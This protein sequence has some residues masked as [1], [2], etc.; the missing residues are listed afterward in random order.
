MLFFCRIFCIQLLLVSPVWL[1]AQAAPTVLVAPANWQQ[2]GLLIQLRD[3]LNHP[4]MNWPLTRL[5]YNLDFKEAGVAL[6]SLHLRDAGTG[7][8]VPFQLTDVQLT[9]GSVRKATLYFLTDLPSGS[10]KTFRLTSEKGSAKPATLE[11]ISVVSIQKNA[12]TLVLSNGFVRAELPLTTNSSKPVPPMLR[13]GNATTWLGSGVLTAGLKPTS[14]T[15]TEGSIGPLLAEYKLA[16]TFGKIK[17]YTATIRLV[18][19]M[20]F[21]ELDERM[22]GFS[23]N[24]SLAWQLVWDHLKPDFRYT[25]NRP[26]A[27]VNPS[28]K[29]YTSFAWEPIGGGPID[30]SAK[31]HPLLPYDQQSQAN[32]KLPFQLTPY[33]NWLS[34]WNLHTVA[35]WNE[36]EN[37]SIGLFINEMEKWNDGDYALWGSNEKLCIQF[38]RRNEVLY[39]RFPLVTGTRSTGLAIYP[40]QKDVDV[41]NK[42]NTPFVYIDYLRRW[43]GWISLDKVKNW[44]LNYPGKENLSPIFF[45]P[46]A[47]KASTE[48]ASLVQ[49]F[50]S[51]LDL[52][53]DH[54]ERSTGPSPVGTRIYYETIMPRW[55]AYRQMMQPEQA[56]Q[57]R[58][59]FLF[60]NQVFMDES[61][62]PIRTMLS[63]H[64]NFLADIKGVPGL[65]AAMFPNHP[66]ARDMADHFEK[67]IALNFKY[68]VRPDVPAWQ[69]T[70]G[71]WTENIGTYTWAFLKPTLRTSY[72]LHHQYDG[73]NRILQPNLSQYANWLLNG[74]TSPLESAGNK[75]VNP[76]QG[77]HAH[78]I[79]P[80]N[81]LRMLGQEMVY[82]D[83][84]TAEHL[85][86]VTSPDDKGFEYVNGRV[87]PWGSITDSEW[88]DNKGTNPHLRSAKYTGYGFTLRHGF[89]TTHEMYVHLQQI[90][91]GPNYRWGRAAQG[92]NGVIYYYANGKRYSHNGPED[93]GDG[94]FGDV[95]R[96]TNFGVKKPGGYRHLG[97]YR[98]VGPNDLAEPLS[99]F[100]F[101]QFAQINAN[102]EALP[103][104]RSRS[105][106]QSGGD[107]ILIFDEVS[108][109]QTEGRFAWF[110]GKDDD[111]PIIQQLSPGVVPVDADIQ[112]SKS[113]YHDDKGER[114]TKGRYYDGKGSFLTV[115][116]HKS[117]VKAQKTDYGCLVTKD[118]GAVDWAFRSTAEKTVSL[119]GMVFQGTAGIIQRGTD[120][121]YK[122]AL[123]SGKQIGIP[124]LLITFTKSGKNAL[125]LEQQTN[126]FS[127]SIQAQEPVLVTFVLTKPQSKRL[128]FYLNGKMLPTQDL[129]GNAVKVRL[130]NGNYTWQWSNTG[131]IPAATSITS[132]THRSEG[133]IITWK[134]IPG[135][136]L[137]RVELSK[138]GGVSWGTIADNLPKTS[139]P[140]QG[141][142][143]GTKVHV[144]ILGKGAGGWSA[145]SDEYPIYVTDQ[146]PHAPEGLLVEPSG[147]R[148]SIRW[149]QILGANRYSLYRREKNGD[150]TRVINVYSG[151]E[152]V[153]FDKT[154]Q[155]A[156]V[157]E[158]WVTATNGNGVSK[159][160][161]MSDTDPARMINWFPKPNESFRRDTR[162]HENG[163][164]E[165]N[166]FVEA[167]KPILTYPASA[168]PN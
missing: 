85:F 139:L 105:V 107:Y 69:A 140:L 152:R 141:L 55:D 7:A 82:Y 90:D 78:G 121:T 112:P 36:S 11:N 97:V 44:V 166:P 27:P 42:T 130:I 147:K 154:I 25:P 15:V 68:H 35:F 39:W 14:L 99:N 58:A 108:N 9:S 66:Q 91:E 67:S 142:T 17:R 106:L 119:D 122:A 115:V 100:G 47:E 62:M 162:S 118:A 159:R 158:Y 111:F 126:G 18:A 135:A 93:V 59:A 102:K 149:G 56:R 96:C 70:G 165:Y 60:M 109:P 3:E 19:G 168:P 77:A 101:A 13:V 37:Q 131:V 12:K 124:G 83:P 74:L 103:D 94:P 133:A 151:P 16:Y 33:D 153:F 28:S 10:T 1:F 110:V 136:A 88:K 31:K 161:T 120:H 64:P 20:D 80:S 125:S 157:Y 21:L 34:W 48:V 57:N 117:D 81:L 75:R 143:N 137:Y 95:E 32:G 92:G 50:A 76:P 45:R 128:I 155:S 5:R 63:G 134:S 129:A 79:T 6:R 73:R 49:T 51:Q 2:Q 38:F 23:P 41:V 72:L 4:K 61:L 114:L 113:N 160:S 53:A 150:S 29:G 163:Y 52:V 86:W 146:V 89:G 84:L 132:T 144:R 156:K 138:D 71:R 116:T 8:E 22:Q 26:G 127:G 24:D 123:F 145:P 30:T 54:S 148:V 65:A 98:S 87:D 164:D 167:A 40:H 46:N 43:Y 104:Y